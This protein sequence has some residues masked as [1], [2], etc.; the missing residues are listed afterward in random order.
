[1]K[2]VVRYNKEKFKKYFLLQDVL[3]S[4]C[5][6][7]VL[8]GNHQYKVHEWQLSHAFEKGEIF[9]LY[10]LRF[11]RILRLIIFGSLAL[12]ASNIKPRSTII[13]NNRVDMI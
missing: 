6:G 10:L 1:M 3:A 9:F 11:Q 8:S 12:H 2:K 7:W 5:E 4:D 13:K